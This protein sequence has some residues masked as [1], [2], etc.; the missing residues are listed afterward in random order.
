MSQSRAYVDKLENLTLELNALE[1]RGSLA[2][3]SGPARAHCEH[4]S[5]FWGVAFSPHGAS[6]KDRSFATRMTDSID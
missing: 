5:G 3:N 4:D 1:K 2:V 6:F